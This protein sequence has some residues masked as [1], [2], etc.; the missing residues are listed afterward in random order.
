MV[1][2]VLRDRQLCHRGADD[3]LFEF[4]NRGDYA[5]QK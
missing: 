2:E 4:V 3:V 5:P 1:L